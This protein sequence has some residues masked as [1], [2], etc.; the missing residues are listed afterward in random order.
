MYVLIVHTNCTVQYG[1][2][3]INNYMIDWRVQNLSVS[4]LIIHA[5][6][7]MVIA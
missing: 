5:V 3:S 2:I 7:I 1:I 4:I 6:Y